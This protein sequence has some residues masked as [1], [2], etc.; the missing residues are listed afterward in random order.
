MTEGACRGVP[1]DGVQP[2]GPGRTRVTNRYRPVPQIRHA[3]PTP[4]AEATFRGRRGCG[5]EGPCATSPA[6]RDPQGGKGGTTGFGA[7]AMRGPSGEREELE[8]LVLET[9]GPQPW[10]RLFHASS[11]VGIWS[12][13]HWFEPA[14]VVAA[15]CVGAALGGALAL[16]IARLRSPTWNVAFFRILRPLASPRERQGIASSTWYLAGV[17]LALVLFPRPLAEAGILVLALADPTASWF[18][19]RYGRT[20]MGGGTRLGSAL[21]LAVTLAVLWPVAGWRALP[22]ALV[23]T[24]AEA[25]VRRVD[26][27]LLIPPLTAGLLGLP[28]AFACGWGTGGGAPRAGLGTPPGSR[29][30][31][32]GSGP[33]SPTPEGRSGG[34]G[35][36]PR[37]A[38]LRRAVRRSCS[39]PRRSP[40]RVRP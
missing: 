13:L 16:D 25:G 4:V 2:S 35:R 11:G 7:G 34:P 30:G 38:G 8:Q 9:Q 18:G 5:Q 36:L 15:G 40:H 37:G 12:W 10:R 6:V 27:N 29:N 31:D 17:L 23:L 21:F 26:D 33:V 14:T 28:G 3:G 32:G 24:A 1:N 39:C 20:R 19:C 22:A